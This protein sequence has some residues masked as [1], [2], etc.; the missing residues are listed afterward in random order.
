MVILKPKRWLDKPVTGVQVNYGHPLAA[1][2]VGCFPLNEG[3]GTN[4]TNIVTGKTY[5]FQGSPAWIRSRYGIGL[6]CSTG[7]DT[8]VLGTAEDILRV[9]KDV[10]VFWRGYLVGTPS[11]NTAFAGV[12]YN[13]AETSPFIAYAS[14]CE[15]SQKLGAWWNNGGAFNSSPGSAITSFT[16]GTVQNFAAA[17][18]MGDNAN[19]VYANK[20][21]DASGSSGGSGGTITYNSDAPLIIGTTKSG[22][23]RNSQSVA[24]AVYIWR[25]RLTLAEINYLYDYPYAIFVPKIPRLITFGMTGG[26]AHALTSTVESI[27]EIKATPLSNSFGLNT[28]LESISEL[29]P[30]PLGKTFNFDSVNVESISEIKSIL[31]KTLFLGSSSIESASEIKADVLKPKALSSTIE[32]ISEIITG[33][34]KFIGA[35]KLSSTIKPIPPTSYTKGY[36]RPIAYLKNDNDNYGVTNETVESSPGYNDF[37]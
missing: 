34:S 25:R 22:D 6:D 19:L 21:Q 13:A 1:G 20:T 31:S 17:V 36:P 16:G 14:S 27:S 10:T 8:G 35:V 23:A 11:A 28:K 9:T 32:S 29:K 12:M 26:V 15:G 18:A 4:V 5:P 33:I 7:N 2:L 3:S 24:L 30:T 37:S